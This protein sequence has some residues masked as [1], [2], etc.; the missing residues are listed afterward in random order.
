MTSSRVRRGDIWWID[1]EPARGGEVRKVRPAV[2][3]SNDVACRVQ[4]RVQVVPITSNVARVH[5]WEAAIDVSGRPCKAMAD[6][7]KTVAK[8]RIKGKIGAASAQEMS[9]V[10]AA[11]RIQLGLT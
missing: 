10:E 9:D 7:L 8:E 6:Q 5:A 4:D 2:V 11:F 3:L 1:F